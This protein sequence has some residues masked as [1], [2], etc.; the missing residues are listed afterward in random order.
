MRRR[1]IRVRARCMATR[2]D[3]ILLQVTPDGIVEVPGG[4]LEFNESIPFC[5]V[6]E[7]RE[8]AGVDV[9]P[10]DLVYIVEFR[11]EKR[12][13]YRHEVL[14][15]FT[16]SLNGE[17]KS[18]EKGLRF[19]WVSAKELSRREF[20]PRPLLPYLLSDIPTFPY[21]RYLSIK[22]NNIEYIIS[23]EVKYPKRERV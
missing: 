19:E 4:R 9:E 14:F 18:K 21:I 8:E 2:G 7:L 15:Y 16:C 12:G 3:S 5:L 23:K 1:P 13:R 10:K 20:W 17:P 6:R 11:G 22:N